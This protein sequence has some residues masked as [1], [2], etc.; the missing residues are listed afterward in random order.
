MTYQSS[1][2]AY[3]DTKVPAIREF[4]AAHNVEYLNH[5]KGLASSLDVYR[6]DQSTSLIVSPQGESGAM[7]LVGPSTEEGIASFLMGL[8]QGLRVALDGTQEATA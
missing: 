3:V 5:S 6:T 8:D 4:C 7:I 1:A 2:R